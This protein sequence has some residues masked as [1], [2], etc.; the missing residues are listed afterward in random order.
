MSPS[1]DLGPAPRPTVPEP[2]H[3]SAADRQQIQLGLFPLHSPLLGESLLVS[4][5]PLSD[6]LKFGGYSCHVEARACAA[7]PCLPCR[8]RRRCDRRADAISPQLP[9][10]AAILSSPLHPFGPVCRRSACT[11]AQRGQCWQRFTLTLS[12]TLSL[13]TKQVRALYVPPGIAARPFAFKNL[14]TRDP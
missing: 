6:M 12:P 9:P 1:R 11:A 7:G 2:G 5:P 14:M 10:V 13:A 4:F 3:N 8:D